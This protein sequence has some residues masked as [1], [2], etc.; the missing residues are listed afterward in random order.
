MSFLSLLDAV[1]VSSGCFLFVVQVQDLGLSGVANSYKAFVLASGVMNGAQREMSLVRHFSDEM[2][3]QFFYGLGER[4][5]AGLELLLQA[6]PSLI[7]W[8]ALR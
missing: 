7:K 5:S 8:K 1:E 6:V 2:G 3:D 4:C